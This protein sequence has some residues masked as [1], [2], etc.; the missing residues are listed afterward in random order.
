[1]SDKKKKENKE[2]VDLPVE[3]TEKIQGGKAPS[4]GRVKQ[5]S[6]DYDETLRKARVKQVSTDYEPGPGTR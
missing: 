6:T 2:C 5:V 1:M 3:E 4:A